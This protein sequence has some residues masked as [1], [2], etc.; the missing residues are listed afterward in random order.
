MRP[1]EPTPCES[2]TPI[3]EKGVLVVDDDEQ[4]RFVM[5]MALADFDVVTASTGKEALDVMRRRGIAVLITDQKMPVMTGVELCDLVATRYPETHRVLVTAYSDAVTAEAAINQG[6]VHRYLRKPWDPIDLKMVVQ[7]GL[8]KLHLETVVRD[9]R[10][11]IA[12]REIEAAALAGQRQAFHDLANYHSV[13]AMGHDSLSAILKDSLGQLDDATSSELLEVLED[14]GSA[15][16]HITDLDRKVRERRMLHAPKQSHCCLSA[17]V[18]MAVNLARA[19][20]AGDV[21]ID[22]DCPE[23]VGVLVDQVD[24][25]RV[26]MNLVKNAIQAIDESGQQNGR[27]ELA[28]K[29]DGGVVR[30][31]VRDNGPGIPRQ[32]RETVFLSGISSRKSNGGTGL[33]LHIARRL[34]QNCGGDIELVSDKNRGATF[35]VTVPSSSA[36]L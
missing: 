9:L 22:V 17:I 20:T 35:M 11:D 26:L 13:V 29:R 18:E 25:S 12:R 19:G 3:K 34:V 15:V 10:Q 21:R 27:V 30:I 2:V 14:I 7:E 1:L 33:G 36:R 28:V 6:G 5:S 16:S 4:N 24:L 8:T 23:D 32:L 31:R